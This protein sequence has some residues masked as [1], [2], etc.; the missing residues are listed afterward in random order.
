MTCKKCG[1]TVTENRLRLLPRTTVCARCSTE[2]PVLTF[3]MYSGKNTSDL[4]VVLPTDKEA[5]RQAVRAF[6]RSR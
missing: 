2:Q 3:P 1:G 6:R 4:C 5:V